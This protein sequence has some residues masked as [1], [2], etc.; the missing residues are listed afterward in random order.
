MERRFDL[1]VIGTGVASK[2]ASRCR[3]AGWSVAVVDSR[4]F[5]GTCA[6]R[7]CIPKKILVAAAEAVHGARALSDKGVRADGVAIDWPARMRV[8]RAVTDPIPRGTEQG[9][10]QAGIAAFHGRAKFVGPATLAV[11]DDRLTGRHVLIAAGSMPQPLSFPGAEHVAT[12]DR[13][14]ELDVLPPRVVFI[15]GGFISFELAHVAARAG[16]RATI[17]HRGP[18]PL[19]AFDPDLVDQLVTR[20]RELGI[21]V[22]LDADVRSVERGAGGFAVTAGVAGQERR[23][24]ADLVVHGAGR[25]PEIHDLDLAVASVTAEK[26]G[27]VVNE[28]LQ[29]VSNP[30][31]YAAGDAAASGP[32]L[33]PV[34]DHHADVVA[35]NLLEGNKKTVDYEGLASAVFTVPPLAS[36]GLTEAAARAQ[37]RRFRVHR[38]NTSGWLST[39]RIGE[40]ASGSKVLIEEES[41]RILGAHLLGPHADEVINVFALAIRLH[42]RAADLEHVLYAYPTVSSDIP[43]MV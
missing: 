9:Y 14:L 16:A 24:D 40:T 11:G 25:V 20:S 4:P 29:S 28:Y 23:F 31:V 32:P 30:A 42:A 15:G 5:G 7:G 27:V 3:A 22:E 34:A 36:A 21:G 1:V 6:L 10:A 19:E 2:A 33:T 35:T 41:G 8:K 37:G 18:R 17:V 13:F 12:S 39:Q 38:E 26:R 43:Y